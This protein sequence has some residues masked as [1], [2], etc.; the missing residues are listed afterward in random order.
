MA[1]IDLPVDIRKS[2]SG[3]LNT[4][5]KKYA[6]SF[7]LV[8]FF[9]LFLQLLTRYFIFYPLSVQ[10]QS[11]FPTLKKGNR[12]FV[13]YPHL[14]NIKKGDVVLLNNDSGNY[15]LLCRLTANEGERVE[16]LNREV[17]VNGKPLGK[18]EAE[19]S[20]LPFDMD[21]SDNMPI[22]DIRAGHFFCLNDNWQM[23]ADSR[24]YGSF[25]F[26]QIQGKVLFKGFPG[27]SIP[28]LK[29]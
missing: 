21:I 4:F 18:V 26:K 16:I 29:R 2:K 17:F 27:F 6:N 15:K 14:A 11:M 28:S 20:P 19:Q 3:R 22:T 8:V 23:T 9:L 12:I 1:Y 25:S 13:L 7:L 10:D 5:F 24:R